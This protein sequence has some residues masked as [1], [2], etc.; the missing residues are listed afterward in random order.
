[1][2]EFQII[3]D[4]VL[5]GLAQFPDESVQCVVTSPPYW[6]LRDYG[7]ATW[8]GGNQECEHR[9]G[10]QAPQTNA[11]QGAIV[12]GVRP[13]VD[14]SRCLDCGAV[15]VDRQLGLE[16]TPEEYVERLVGIFREVRRVLRDDGTVWLV[17]GDSYAR[18]PGKG[19]SGPNGKHD[20]IP[21]YGGA[22]KI[23]SDRAREG[24]SDGVV[25]RSD[26]PGSRASGSGL[27]PKDLVGIPW[28]VAFA[29][30]ADGWY[31]RSDIIW[32]LSG[33][34]R[35]YAR[36]QKGEMPTT[37]KD[38]VRLDPSTVQL[39][40]GEKWTQV[41]GWNRSGRGE[42]LEIE[43]RSGERIGCTEGHL[44]PTQ[45]GNVQADQ[46]R[47]GDVLDS[48]TL[49]EPR[50]PHLP[51]HI[52]QDV[53]WMVGLYLA[54]GSQSRG[55]LQF[56]GHENEA[57]WRVERLAEIAE[58]FGGTVRAHDGG[59]NV[60]VDCPPLVAIVD[61]YIHG[62]SAK[63]KGIKVRAWR[64][65]N[66]WLTAFLNGYLHGDGHHDAN[67]GRWRLGFTRNDRLA[68]D[69]R[70]ICARLGYTLTL[71]AATANG[72]G[73]EWP[74]Y[75]GEIRRIRSGHHNERSR[76]EVVAIR[77]SRAR[78]FWDIGVADEPHLFALAS[79][80][81]THN[82]KP[83][84]MPESVK[85]RPTKAHEY[86]FL[87]S[88]GATYYYDHEAIAEPH[89]E[90]S[91]ARARR[92]RFGGKYQSSDPTEHGRLKAGENYGPDGDPDK[93]CRP[94]GRNKRSVWT[95]P[96]KPFPEAHFAVYPTKLIEPCILAGS[97]EGHL[98]LD[99]FCGS[100]TTGVVA[101]RL[102]RRFVGIELKP[103][104]AEMARR[105]ITEDGPLLNRESSDLL[106]GS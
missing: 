72:F 45:R 63:T 58:R 36:T 54:E 32:C 9:V 96:T 93:V 29:L 8:E 85:D 19:G 76:S 92:N 42:P 38:L 97:A 81:L 82:S 87:L 13:G 15:R 50:V 5:D 83:N 17:L 71:R 101:L 94:G 30:Q 49:P 22:R 104:Y 51:L 67:N 48:A 57:A 10:R 11:P 90:V 21:D 52:D 18:G 73:K 25:G 75:R 79:G 106:A 1:M 86:I 103:E 14:A 47:V 99:P 70:T 74:C 78:Q 102:G 20:F 56:A 60:V 12:G 37:I 66:E 77:R 24:S 39:W 59:A 7:T 33:G 16:P 105:R 65:D 80:V 62:K 84:P 89:A 53:A 40:N 26:R 23:M 68:G 95:I 91:L 31:L 69:L 98:V 35:V 2:R 4:D 61:Q 55:R 3:E 44:W 41:L 88:K 46:L 6:G 100:G 43:L 27:K 34:T 28:R 64:H